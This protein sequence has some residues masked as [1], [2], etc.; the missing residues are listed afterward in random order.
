MFDDIFV[1][2]TDV[3]NDHISPP[4]STLEVEQ[5]SPASEV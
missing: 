4:A 5:K 3:G 2:H 1:P